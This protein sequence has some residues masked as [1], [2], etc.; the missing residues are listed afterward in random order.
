MVPAAKAWSYLYFSSVGS[1]I[2]PNSTI[3]AP[4][5]PVVAPMITPKMMMPTP[6]PPGTRPAR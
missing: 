4:T 6:M 1:A 5:M 3:V 2:T